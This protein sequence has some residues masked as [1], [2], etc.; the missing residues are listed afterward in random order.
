MRVH[1]VD[2]RGRFHTRPFVYSLRLHEGTFDQY[3]EDT[4]RPLPLKFLAPLTRNF[5][6]R[7]RLV[8]SSYWSKV[9]SC[10]LREYTKGRVWKRPRASTKWTRMGDRKSVG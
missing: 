10:S 8:S 1:F 5:S 4:S 7:G 9:P 2:A 6:G 3:E